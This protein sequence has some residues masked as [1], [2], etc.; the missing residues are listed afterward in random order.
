MTFIHF[1]YFLFSIGLSCQ[2]PDPPSRIKESVVQPQQE[3]SKEA[4]HRIPAKRADPNANKRVSMG[5]LISQNE[6]PTVTKNTNKESS[7][8]DC[9]VILITVCSLRKDH[10]G[11][12]GTF[13]GLTPNIDSLAKDAYVFDRAYASSNFTLASLTS[14]LTGHFGSSTGVTGWDKGLTVDIKT[15]PQIM[16]LYGFHTAAF[17][18]DAASGFRPEYGLDKGFHRMEISQA[19][20]N[21]PDGR[22]LK[23]NTVVQE[24]GD[25]ASALPLQQWL[26]KRSTKK[27][28]FV[29]HHNRTPIFHSSSLPTTLKKTV[30][31]CPNCCGKSVPTSTSGNPCQEVWED[32]KPREWSKI[33]TIRCKPW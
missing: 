7:C 25:G 31:V 29:M 8:S 16:S 13:P 2:Y 27:P 32:P 33:R 26:E 28:V 24:E 30:Q 21:T 18:I 10:V 14:I 1:A 22:G 20:R 12:Y 3:P 6:V 23:S 9:D 4:N 15:I 19:P 5:T 17:T 11:H